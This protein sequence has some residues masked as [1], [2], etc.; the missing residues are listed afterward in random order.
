[1]KSF[2]VKSTK[3]RGNDHPTK[4]K[5]KNVLKNEN[6]VIQSLFHNQLFLLLV[7]VNSNRDRDIHGQ[8]LCS[9]IQHEHNHK[10]NPLLLP[11]W[12][13]NKVLSSHCFDG[14][15]QPENTHTVIV[16]L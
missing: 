2:I 5:Y 4:M 11:F 12:M 8:R 15:L 7:R 16:A 1:M 9:L 13:N 14:L 3:S 10:N 6:T